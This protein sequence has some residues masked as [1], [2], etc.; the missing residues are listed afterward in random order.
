MKRCFY[1]LS[2]VFLTTAIFI[3]CAENKKINS[4][5]NDGRPNI[6][7]IMADDLGIALAAWPDRF[8][9]LCLTKR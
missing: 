9:L 1:N 3:S 5:K 2:I 4:R 7:L 8:L 6:L